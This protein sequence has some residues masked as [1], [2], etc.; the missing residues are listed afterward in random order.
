MAQL[1]VIHKHWVTLKPYLV[2]LGIFAGSRVIV[3]LAMVFSSKFVERAVGE[4][5]N[6]VTPQWYRH[7][8]H[9]DSAWYL[10]IATEGYS[11]NGNN[12][13]LQQPVVFYPFY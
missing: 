4:I 13:Q 7:L 9:W 2:A 5:F 3:F 11:Y 6:D 1:C 8:L 12:D 10:R